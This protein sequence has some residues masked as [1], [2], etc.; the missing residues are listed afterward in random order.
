MLV[1]M[2]NAS[3]RT[4]TTRMIGENTITRASSHLG[5]LCFAVVA[6]TA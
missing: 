2:N 3:T 4:T 6:L 1:M 5:G